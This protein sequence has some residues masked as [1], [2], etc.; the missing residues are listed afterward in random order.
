[1]LCRFVLFLGA[2][3]VLA[4]LMPQVDAAWSG[5]LPAGAALEVEAAQDDRDVG[6]RGIDRPAR[7][8]MAVAQEG[9]RGGRG[10]EGPGG[11]KAGGEKAG[12]EKAGGEKAG[13]KK[14]GGGAGRDKEMKRGRG[15]EQATTPVIGWFKETWTESSS[16]LLERFAN[17]LLSGT[18]FFSGTLL[19][20]VGILLFGVGSIL[21]TAVSILAAC[22]GLALISLSSAPLPPTLYIAG[23]FVAASWLVAEILGKRA[24]R[25]ALGLRIVLLGMCVF[26]IVIELPYRK[27]PVIELANGTTVCV[28]GDSIS[29]GIGFPGETTWDDVLRDEYGVAIVNLSKR[30]A[31]TEA[32]AR[33]A[34]DLPDG[35]A[36]VI[37]E[38]GGN[39]ILKGNPSGEYAAALDRLLAD[40]VRDGSK[41]VLM[42]ELPL[43]PFH[44]HYG[45]AQR[46]LAE[47]HGVQ[48]VPKHVLAGVMTGENARVDHV[49]L[50]NAGHA[51]LAAALGRVLGRSGG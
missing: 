45:R 32:I 15:K 47:R 22:A 37:V 25:V 43:P 40:L 26:G 36:V 30:G 29:S 9:A 21:V 10:G 27:V 42:M 11:E 35:D 8:D 28:L 2:C 39:D 31:R 3:A 24:R 46:Q 44:A 7:R 17:H 50:S 12:G 1:M 4:G 41:R 14:A 13:G 48:L 18:A 33:R 38:I 20:A 51:A 49:H 23:C 19:L 16:P 5:A 34:D 6:Q